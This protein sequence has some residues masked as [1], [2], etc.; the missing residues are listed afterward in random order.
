MTDN[1]HIKAEPSSGMTYKNNLRDTQ[2]RL[3]I[4][5]GNLKNVVLYETGGGREYIT[6]NI[7]YLLGY[8]PEKFTENRNYFKSLI[9]P[10]DT[11][12]LD[13]QFDEWYEN[14]SEDTL[15]LEF[16]CKKSNGDYI[17]LEDYINYINPV[18]ENPYMTGILIDI[19]GRKESEDTIKKSL[20]EKEILLR[21]IHHRVNNNLQV[22]SSLLKIQSVYAEDDIVKEI[23]KVTLNRIRSMAVIHQLTCKSNNLANIDLNVYLSEFSKYLRESYNNK[24]VHFEVNS[25]ECVIINIDIA[26]PCGLL[27]NELITLILNNTGKNGSR[28]EISYD[29][30]K[31]FKTNDIVLILHGKNCSAVSK[32][33]FSNDT[34]GL[35]LVSTLIEQ[36]SGR[37]ETDF[38]DGIKF[39]VT[40]KDNQYLERIS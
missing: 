36:I 12:D 7:F 23:F 28:I 39:T 19:T 32:E 6:Q 33:A 18:G 26:V 40:F 29:L 37:L 11:K 9:H 17:W 30:K 22:I 2:M 13:L 20:R 35:Q 16:R 3:A 5:I 34:L 15:K 31:K 21:E 14:G 38:S 27:I 8:P 10:E 24:D 4:L 1:I 25:K